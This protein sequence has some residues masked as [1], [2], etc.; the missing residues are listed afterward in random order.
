[1][2]IKVNM[3]REEV[4]AYE[5]I[6]LSAESVV[7]GMIWKLKFTTKQQQELKE[8][9]ESRIHKRVKYKHLLSTQVW[10]KMS[11]VLPKQA[12]FEPLMLKDTDQVLDAFINKLEEIM[13]VHKIIPVQRTI[14]EVHVNSNS[15]RKE[16][17]PIKKKK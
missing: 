3:E 7:P 15:G 2:V 4:S 8:K 11:Y 13:E 17:K 10:D 5:R 1:M 16:I 14:D 6:K 9:I 12:N